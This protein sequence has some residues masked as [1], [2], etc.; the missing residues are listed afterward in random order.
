MALIPFELFLKTRLAAASAQVCGDPEPSLA[1]MAG[2]PSSY[3]SPDGAVADTARTARQEIERTAAHC[4]PGGTCEFEVIHTEERDGIAF[5]AGY[6][7]AAIMLQGEAA[8]RPISLR[9]TEIFRA[10][11]QGWGLSHR[12]AD[13]VRSAKD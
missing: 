2:D 10:G 1:M 9:V 6:Q 12:H 13:P 5:W 3:F 8:L 7:H 4:R 11:D